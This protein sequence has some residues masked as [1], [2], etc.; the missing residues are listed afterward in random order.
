MF[1]PEYH[2]PGAENARELA[3]VTPSGE[4]K[5]QT[6]SGGVL[7]NG[8]V[9][10]PDGKTYI[11]AES[12]AYVITAFDRAPDGTLSNKRQLA[13][14]KTALHKRF[15]GRFDTAAAAMPDGMCLDS[16]GGIWCAVP[17]VLFPADPMVGGVVRYNMAGEITHEF[18]MDAGFD[19]T[20]IAVMFGEG[21]DLYFVCSRQVGGSA[22]LGRDNGFLVKV[23]VPFKAAKSDEFPHY[24][25]GYC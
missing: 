23:T 17:A 11:V 5:M 24:H 3:L 9:I 8:A 12:L 6:G 14:C 16:E 2:Q 4:I 25:A 15:P 18:G 21:N 19:G 7:H 22:P 1:N 20:G 10:T 13:D